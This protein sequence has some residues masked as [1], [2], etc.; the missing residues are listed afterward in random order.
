MNEQIKEVGFNDRAVGVLVG[1]ASGDALGAA[2]EFG[3]PIENEQQIGMIG[4]GPFNWE[5]GEWTDDTSM[6]MPIANEIAEGRDLLDP[7]TL[8]NI[9]SAWKDW[10]STAK[11]VGVQT[12]SVLR[13]L[14][15][16]TEQAAREASLAHHERSNQ[17]GGNGALMRTAPVALA[18]LHDKS[19]LT[20][21]ATRIAQLTHWEDDAAE[22]CVICCH[23]IRHA[24]V[25]GELD[26]RVGLSEFD[27]D[28]RLKWEERLD[29]AEAKQ[30]CDFY[31]SNGWVVSA[32]QGAWSAI[33]HAK[34][35]GEGIVE[36]LERAVRGGGDT[37]TVA[38][39]AGGL[40]GAYFGVSCIPA[41]WRRQIHGW[42][43]YTYRDLMNV[44]LACIG[45][46]NQDPTTGWPYVEQ[47]PGTSDDV[48]VQHPHDDGVWL[49]SLTGL[50]RLPNDVDAI[51]SLC[52][53][54]TNQV[55][56]I[57]VIEFWLID[58]PGSN[59]DTEFVLT[60]AANTIA[61]LRER[62][63]KVVIHCVAAHNRTP[64]AAIAYSI[65]EKDV[66]FTEAW[67][68][69]RDALPDPQNNEDFRRVLKHLCMP[70]KTTL[71]RSSEL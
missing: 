45:G 52:R 57:E 17:S 36:T 46:K 33:F 31:T 11:D 68:D 27:Q 64:A 54:G 66:P 29:E 13:S 7:E 30:P 18:Y 39:I 55:P 56:K 43:G 10:A 15:E 41:Q 53:V 65:L 26:V 6:A 25:T 59:L 21:A 40:A 19:G 69:V 37:D 67:T 14:S 58:N 20:E 51:I 49:A 1:L 38:A 62:G 12:S 24:V 42:P 16:T 28:V 4:G 60:D 50:N 71:T 3:G 35:A 47:M 44:A 32:L 70:K 2:Y 22:A 48:L 61:E 34:Q 5:P 8:G 23:A 9:V 63:K